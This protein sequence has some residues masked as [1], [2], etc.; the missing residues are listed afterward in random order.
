MKRRI[1]EKI[2]DD[3]RSENIE[4]REIISGEGRRNGER[5]VD[6]KMWKGRFLEE[7]MKEVRISGEKNKKIVNGIGNEGLRS[8]EILLRVEDWDKKKGEKDERE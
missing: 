8:I 1:L 3:G 7:I 2:L 6:I 4:E 5:K